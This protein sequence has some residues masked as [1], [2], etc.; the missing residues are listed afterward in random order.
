VFVVDTLQVFI[1]VEIDVSKRLH[2]LWVCM[3]IKVG[4]MEVRDFVVT[5]NKCRS[6]EAYR[7]R[8]DGRLGHSGEG[9]SPL[10]ISTAEDV[11][12]GRVA[13]LHGVVES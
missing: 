2:I 13:W 10:P 11:R 6:D 5:G 12:V 4:V 3:S 1:I 7:W 9:V 8:L